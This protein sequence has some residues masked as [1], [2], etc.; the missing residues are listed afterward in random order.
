MGSKW[1]CRDTRYRKIEN[2]SLSSVKT[3]VCHKADETGHRTRSSIFTTQVENIN[4]DDWKKIKPCITFLKQSKEDKR[5]IGCFN[6]KVFFTWVDAL[7]AMHKNM[8]GHTGGAMSMRY[9]MIHCRSIKQK[10]NT[11]ST[12]ESELVD[13]SAYMP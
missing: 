6:L 1:E 4:V 7:F 10:L 8:Q 5:I 11:K 9:G 2:I 3:I 12:N 13:T